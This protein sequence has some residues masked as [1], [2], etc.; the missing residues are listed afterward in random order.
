MTKRQAQKEATRRRVL[1]A[2]RELF[3]E[4]GYEETTLRAVAERAHIS[5]G[6]VFTSFESKGELL[7]QVMQDRLET[8][9]AELDRMLPHIRGT[10]ADRIRSAFA[11]F[12]A[13]EMRHA[14]LF[15]AHI[16]QTYSWTPGS[17]IIPFGHNLRLQGMV[18]A[19]LEGGVARGEIRPDA[20][21]DIAMQT[22]MAS[23]AWNFRLAS[24]ENADADALTAMMDRQIGLIFEGIA[25]AR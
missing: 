24:W 5:V 16:A 8:L 1:D 23:F 18:R 19:A 20:D 25:T 12:Y 11:M 7:S 13:F 15:L 10:T 17:P 6:S 2:A 21:L 14:R 3:D 22:L 4:I 9:Y